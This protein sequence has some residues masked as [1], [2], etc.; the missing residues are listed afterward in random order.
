MI[1]VFREPCDYF[2]P[3]EPGD[4]LSIMAR[5]RHRPT[6]G[7]TLQRRDA[8]VY[9]PAPTYRMLLRCFLGYGYGS[10]DATLP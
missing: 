1:A 8:R 10:I 3:N 2:T 5:V 9:R 6:A 7:E 4:L